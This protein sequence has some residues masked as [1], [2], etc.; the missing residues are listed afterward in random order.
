MTLSLRQ[1][2]T[3]LLG[4]DWTVGQDRLREYDVDGVTPQAAIQAQDRQAVADILSWAAAQRLSVFPRGGGTQMSLGNVPDGVGL[5]LAMGRQ[6]RVLDYE[7]ADLTATVEAGI[8]LDQLQGQLSAGEQFLP[9]ES[10]LAE[11]STIGGVLAANSTGA[12]RYSYGQPRDWLIGIAVVGAEG[13][14]TKAGGKVVKNVTGYDLN[15]LYTGSMGTLGVIVEATFKLSPNPA[16]RGALVAGFQTLDRGIDAGRALLQQPCAPQGVQVVDGQAARKL[17]PG[18]AFLG[19]P[20]TNEAL[21]FAF[22]SGRPMAL[23]R[24]M[25]ECVRLFRDSGASDVSM[26]DETASS[27]LQKA[28]NDVGWSENNRPY[29]GIKLNLPPSSLARVVD[30]L[31][32]ESPVGLP[33]GVVADPGFGVARLFWWSESVSEWIDYS[34]ALDVI[35]RAREVARDEGGSALVEFCP[36]PLKAQIDVWGQHPHGIEVM[37]RIKQN[38]DPLGILSPGRFV[39][40]I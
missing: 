40:R 13:Q 35:A 29:L 8:T 21:A 25:D 27:E 1:Q 23:N 20:G 22:F 24:K 36:L 5:V 39:G 10:P 32:R 4:Q 34:L 16:R 37:R 30:R 26:L 15:K 38:F 9:L 12:L 31:R 14:E 18:D 28:L 33:P 19:V 3:V 6:S 17:G 7:P 2:L 11:K